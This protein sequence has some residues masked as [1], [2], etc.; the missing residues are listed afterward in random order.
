MEIDGVKFGPCKRCGGEPDSAIWEF[1]IEGTSQ[2]FCKECNI[3]SPIITNL[4][5]L[6]DW[7]N[8]W[9]AETELETLRA[10]NEKLETELVEM[11]EWYCHLYAIAETR[12][13]DFSEKKKSNDAAVQALSIIKKLKGGE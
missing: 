11:C 13:F 2:I 12:H 1:N 10:E 3:H 7:W 8:D 4:Y 9:P 5:V 6:A